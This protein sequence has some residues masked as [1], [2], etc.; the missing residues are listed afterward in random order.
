MSSITFTEDDFKTIDSDHVDPMV[1]TI[2]VANFAIMRAPVDQG[3]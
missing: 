1:V 2:G 3:S